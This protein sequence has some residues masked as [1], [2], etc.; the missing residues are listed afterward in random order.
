[1]L[2]AFFNGLSGLFAFSKGLDNVS[3]NVSNMNTPG[4]R[5]SDTFYRSL[6]GADAKGLG[7]GVAG[8]EVRTA[9]GDPKQTGNT[10]DLAVNGN[11][12][13]VLRDSVGEVFY[14]RSGQ[15][16]ISEDGYLIDT[17]S[18]KRVA[19]ISANGALVDISIEA[20][21]SLPPTPTTKVE[22]V[23]ALA[24]TGPTDPSYQ[25]SAVKVFDSMG[26]A[27][28][29]TL[30][31]AQQA[32]PADSWQVTV[33]DSAGNILGSGVIAFGLDGSP[34]AGSSTVTFDLVAGQSITLDFGVPGSFNMTYQVAS[35]AAHS[36]QARVVDGS[37]L[38]GLNS[39]TF[40]ASGTA[41]FAY[42]N[43]EKK[44]GQQVALASFANEGALV[45]N[46]NS[47]YQA[48][49]SV[50]VTYGRAAEGPFGRIMGGY[51]ELSNVDLSQEFGDILIIQRGYQASSRV[52]TVSNEMLE[53]LYN[54]T[55]GG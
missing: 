26:E 33:E 39:I 18:Q 3:N 4:F 29:V 19:G 41:N 7:S 49:T 2:Q 27:H 31:F 15:F 37:A 14:T 38:A 32:S 1:M 52:M 10:T 40:D 5:G 13:F 6:T 28:T 21:R 44:T 51:V 55:R 12:Y 34:Q 48:P 53:Q 24:R 9:A 42:S 47:L 11:G 46:G 35:A 50:R 16:K 45:L 36:L 17:V 8:A 20:Y 23:G 43:G 54:S 30:K 25:I 22:I